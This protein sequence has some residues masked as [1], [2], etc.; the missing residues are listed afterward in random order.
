MHLS[1]SNRTRWQSS[2]RIVVRSHSL[3]A[4]HSREWQERK[5]RKKKKKERIGFSVSFRFPQCGKHRFSIF[6]NLRL[7]FI[8]YTKNIYIS[9]RETSRECTL[10]HTARMHLVVLQIFSFYIN[11]CPFPIFS[12]PSSFL[13]PYFKAR[14][15]YGWLQHSEITFRPCLDRSVIP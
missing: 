4:T 9:Y 11:L 15:G 1:I 3:K 2:A 8:T 7:L 13:P 10:L 14:K 5:K 6:A 12:F